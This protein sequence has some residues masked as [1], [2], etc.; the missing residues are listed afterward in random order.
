[1]SSGVGNAHDN[2]DPARLVLTPVTNTWRRR[3]L[4]RQP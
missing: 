2:D 4:E 1:M 3:M